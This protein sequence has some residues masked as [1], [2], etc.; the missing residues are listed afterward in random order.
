MKHLLVLSAIATILVS[1][2]NSTVT[3]E[4]TSFTIPATGSSYTFLTY[5]TDSLDVKIPDSDVST[6]ETVVASGITFRGKSGVWVIASQSIGSDSMPYTDTT[7]F[8]VDQNNDILVYGQDSSSGDLWIRLPVTSGTAFKDSTS[9]QDEVD[10]IQMEQ[11]L[12]VTSNRIGQEQLTI[13]TATIQTVKVSLNVTVKIIALGQVVS[14]ISIPS[15]AWYAPSLGN[16][17]RMD[18]PTLKIGDAD[19]NLNL[20]GEYKILQS[21]NVL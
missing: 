9:S 14:E 11:R 21:Y 15:T 20:F 17:I 12:I 6:R 5:N 10:G 3:P 4:S 1:C 18:Q 2:S 13:G 7:Y 19:L 8:G 16:I